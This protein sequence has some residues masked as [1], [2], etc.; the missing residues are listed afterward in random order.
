MPENTTLLL[1]GTG[2]TLQEDNTVLYSPG[3]DHGIKSADPL[4]YIETTGNLTIG[5]GATLVVSEGASILLQNLRSVGGTDTLDGI[6][7]P[8]LN[9]EN[10]GKLVVDG[11][12]GD[13]GF[14]NINGDA[15]ALSGGGSVT[16]HSI[17]VNDPG[18]VNGSTVTLSASELNLSGSGSYDA[19]HIKDSTVHLSSGSVS[20]DDLNTSGN[21][22]F[23]FSAGCAFDLDTVDGSL[24]LRLNKPYEDGNNDRDLCPISGQVE[25]SGTINLYAGIFSLDSAMTLDGVT[26]S[27][28]SAALIYDYAG[29]CGTSLTPLRIQPQYAPIPAATEDGVKISVVSSKL[30]E[31]IHH[32]DEFSFNGAL[33]STTIEAFRD[34]SGHLSLDLG[35]LKTLAQT[36]KA[37]V[38][39]EESGYYGMVVE[40][41]HMDQDGNFSTS[42]Y[43]ASALTGTVCADDICLVRITYYSAVCG[44]DP[45]STPTQ[46]GFTFT[47]S[48]IL[49]GSGAGS[50]SYGSTHTI[51]RSPILTNPILT[52]PIRMKTKRKKRK[53]KKKRTRPKTTGRR[54]TCGSRTWRMN[55]TSCM[56]P[57]VCKRSPSTAAR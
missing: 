11:T 4:S 14:V 17:S 15:G 18:N 9:T 19:L 50:V 29:L 39:A 52:N 54:P 51:R 42:F 8:T 46:T 48:G 2:A 24:T 33:P 7:Y 36:S 1:C 31:F 53:R 40:L 22:T 55:A 30:F 56:P 27:D 21:T 25:G 45:V 12:V 34:Q 20:F 32:V 37:A 3:T 38:Q 10:G 44:S 6:R 16:A 23:I 26:L 28:G 41:L 13:G 43:N 35:A 47:G 57:R 5:S 49:G